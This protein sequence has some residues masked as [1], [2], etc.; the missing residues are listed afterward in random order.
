METSHGATQGVTTVA[1]ARV[2]QGKA[3]DAGEAATKRFS[4]VPGPPR[5]LHKRCL[6]FALCSVVPY[7]LGIKVGL[8]WSSCAPPAPRFPF[9]EQ[10][11]QLLPADTVSKR[12]NRAREPI[13]WCPTSSSLPASAQ[14]RDCCP[15]KDTGQRMKTSHIHKEIFTEHIWCWTFIQNMQ[16]ILLKLPFF[17]VINHI[18]HNSP[19]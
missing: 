6:F 1:A 18:P 11:L 5:V 19:T 7:C 13:P 16:R 4:S 14:T 10:F 2:P 3:G 15:V 17:W 9:G 8:L 12:L